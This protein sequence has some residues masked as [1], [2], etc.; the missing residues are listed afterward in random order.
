[1][2]ALN[3]GTRHNEILSLTRKSIDWA[4]RI[5]ALT[6]TKNVEARHVYPNDTALDSLRSLPPRLD[7]LCLFPIGPNQATML[8][9]RAVKRAA[10]EDF[11][12][13]DLRHTFASYQAALRRA[14]C[15][16]SWDTKARA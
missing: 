11:R 12:L 5:G 15:N 8:F 4:N 10:I 1:M 14:A 9:R 6:D 16:H 3:T 2:F 7:A 13:H